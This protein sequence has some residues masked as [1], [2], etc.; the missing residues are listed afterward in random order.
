MPVFL[1]VFLSPIFVPKDQLQDW[2][3]VVVTVNPVTHLL[4]AMRSLSVEGWRSESLLE[5]FA[6]ALA[7]AAAMLAWSTRVA[8]RA[9]SPS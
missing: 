9:T 1:L 6:V 7:L 8:R 5:G 2:M 4:E 3:Q